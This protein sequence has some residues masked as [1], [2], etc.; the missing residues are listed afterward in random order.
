MPGKVTQPPF[1]MTPFLS[2][3]LVAFRDANYA[4]A[5]EA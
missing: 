3:D 2:Q 5:A 1:S 4:A